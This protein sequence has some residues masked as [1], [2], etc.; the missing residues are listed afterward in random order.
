MTNSNKLTNNN[1]IRNI[2]CNKCSCG[3][4]CTKIQD[5][6]VAI[7]KTEI[8]KDI[9]LHIHCGDLTA[10]IGANGAGKS[11]LL[12]ALLG[13]IPHSGNITFVDGNKKLVR[14]LKMGYVP[15]K[16]D[17]D[18]SSPVSVLDIFSAALS[19][20]PVW[21]S[22]SK[23]IRKKAL[24]S[25]SL[26]EGEYLIDR[27]LGVLS[28]GELQRVLLALALQPIPDILLLDEPV[29]G[30]DQNGLKLFYKTVSNL[31]KDYDLSIIL[32]SHDL[33]LV[34]RY[35]DRIAF[36]NNKTIE[37]CGTPEEV[38]SNEKVIDVF[39]VDWNKVLINKN[40]EDDD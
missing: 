39:G 9:N 28:G 31:R 8:L 30:I 32:V 26:V 29:S 33:P 37:C 27:R 21:F 36:I 6:G 12:K 1:K 3:L 7:G 10:L 17:F 35:A 11:T 15:Q 5:F 38:F 23:N 25:L 40:E 24:E 14:K 2:N 16:L 20:K 18:Y 19:I 22:I 34:S 4:C 13:G